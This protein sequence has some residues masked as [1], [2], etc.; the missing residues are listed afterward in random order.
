MKTIP[1]KLRKNGFNYTQVLRGK[2]SCIYEQEVSPKTKR[3]EVF[4]IKVKP[5]RKLNNKVL[6]ATEMFPHNEAFG[7]WAWS[8]FTYE[9]AKLKFDDLERQSE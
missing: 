3:Y 2:I 9:K 5:E 6:P 7:G 8:C 1:L 4:L